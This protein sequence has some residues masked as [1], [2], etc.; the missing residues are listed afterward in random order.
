MSTCL[1]GNGTMLV[2]SKEAASIVTQGVAPR[3][4]IPEAVCGEASVELEEALFSESLDCTVNRALVGV[5]PIHLLLHLLDTGLHKVKWQTA[6]CCT[7][8]C[9]QSASQHH[10]LAILGKTSCLKFFLGLHVD[11]VPKSGSHDLL[12]SCLPCYKSHTP[13]YPKIAHDCERAYM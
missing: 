3:R 1:Q 6:G 2:R 13:L 12:R 7:E 9:N 4:G 8:P 11:I 10:R 5:C